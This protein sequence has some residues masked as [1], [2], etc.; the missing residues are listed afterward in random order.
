MFAATDAIGGPGAESLAEPTAPMDEARD[1]GSPLSEAHG[2]LPPDPVSADGL[3]ATGGTG[4][5]TAADSAAG[6]LDTSPTGG[7]SAGGLGDGGLAAPTAAAPTGSA[8][9]GLDAD[10]FYA[11]SLTD[12]NNGE[13]CA[14]LN[15]VNL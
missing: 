4:G 7:L 9:G 12:T 5:G 8:S 14:R 11:G 6:G 10:G 15:E 13:E 1:G 3:S 2:A